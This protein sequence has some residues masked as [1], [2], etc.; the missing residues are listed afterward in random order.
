MTIL[1]V[2]VSTTPEVSNRDLAAGMVQKMT[3]FCP[4]GDAWTIPLGCYLICKTNCNTTYVSIREQTNFGWFGGT[5]NSHFT[6]LGIPK[7][8]PRANCSRDCS[9]GRGRHAKL[10]KND[11][12]PEAVASLGA[13]KGGVFWISYLSCSINHPK[14]H[15]GW[16]ES[17]PDG[18]IVIGFTTFLGLW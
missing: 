12:L 14:N 2:L 7:S 11:E 17:F 3:R 8:L 1:N 16:N 10:C 4:W 9:N 6:Q 5:T 15:T 18:R 13:A